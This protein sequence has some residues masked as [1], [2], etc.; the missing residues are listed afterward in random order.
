MGAVAVSPIASPIGKDEGEVRVAAR[1]SSYRD[2]FLA[3]PVERVA[4]IKAGVRARM[5]KELLTRLDIS[6]TAGLAALNL[7]AATVNR[8]VA[9]DGTLSVAEGERVIGMASLIGQ[10]EAMVEQS[11]RPD[12]FDAA[13]WMSRW[14]REPAPA[15]G[16]A[17]PVEFMDTMQGQALVSG[18]LAKMQSGAYG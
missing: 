1:A 12:G 17:A 13:A 5:V 4:M 15:L 10:L 14:L 9:Q 2:I 6:Q 16:G 3:E 11:G 8:K 7:P 18:L